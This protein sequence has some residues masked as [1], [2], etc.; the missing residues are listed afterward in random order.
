MLRRVGIGADEHLLVLGDLAEAGPDLLAVDDEL[1]AVDDGARRAALARSEPAFGS[2]KP[3]HQTTSPLRIFGQVERLLLSVPLAI[4]VG[5]ACVEP[6]E[7]R[8]DVGRAAP[9]RTPRTR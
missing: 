2:E 4:S 1:V 8:V 3:W 7:A 6:D 5:P 9:V